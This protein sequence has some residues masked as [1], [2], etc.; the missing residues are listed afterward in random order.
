MKIE[1]KKVQ[2]LYRNWEGDSLDYKGMMY[3]DGI[4]VADVET[5]GDCATTNITPI[6][7]SVEKLISKARAFC[8]K[9]PPQPVPT[10]G[11]DAFIKMNLETYLYS[12]VDEYESLKADIAYGK[13]VA[14]AM[15]SGI[16]FGTEKNLRVVKF[17]MSITH[18]RELGSKG[19]AIIK[20]AIEK[21]VQ[22]AKDEKIF[23]TNIPTEILK[24]AGLT[25]NQY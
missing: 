16:V 18:L 12:L 19:Y 3:I 6:N 23:N 1:L 24:S 8:K 25:K 4:H 21:H 17:G 7:K 13:K 9:M 11:S 20:E 2:N 22:L 10:F 15:E 5:S 14:R